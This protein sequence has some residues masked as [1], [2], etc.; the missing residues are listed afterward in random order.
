MPIEASCENCKQPYYCYPSELEKGRKYCS[1]NCRSK[2]RF[3]KQ[4]SAK[5]RTPVNFI[6]RECSNPF[7]MMQSYLTAY[8][9][10]F[11][12]DPLYCSMNCANIGRRKDSDERN[13]FV[14]ENCGK[15]QH[16]ARKAQSGGRIYREQKYCSYECKVEA[17]KKKAQQK[18][19]SGG[20]K[21]HAKKRDGYVWVTIPE[22]SRNGGAKAILEHRYVMSKHLGRDLLPEET[23]HHINGIRS[24]NQIEN[25]ELFS[26]RHGPGQRVVDKVQFAIEILTLYPEFAK[27]A[28]YELHK[29]THATVSPP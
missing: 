4:L 2:H 6:C 9:K 23:V 19:E 12:Q 25:L 15:E 29:L 14:C 16:R 17:Q 24:E 22:L 5:S 11:G 26:S 3:A 27:T 1:L 8:Q 18:F 10:K 13:K 20:Y 28:G 21:K 7:T